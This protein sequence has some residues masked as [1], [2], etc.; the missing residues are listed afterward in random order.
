MVKTHEIDLDISIFNGLSNNTSIILEQDED[1]LIEKEDYIL[2]RQV[3]II[4]DER[5]QTGLY[6]LVQ[7][8][9][10]ISHQGLK[11]GFILIDYR[12]M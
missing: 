4:E 1:K 8:N 10:V 12:R 3:E 5:R 11:D 7:V 2:F 9:D 6:M